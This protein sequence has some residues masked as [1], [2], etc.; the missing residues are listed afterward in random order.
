MKVVADRK[1]LNREIAPTQT[2]S[3]ASISETPP[4]PHRRPEES[5]YFDPQ[6]NPMGTPPPGYPP[7]YRAPSSLQ[8]PNLNSAPPLPPQQP[9]IRPNYGYLNTHFAQVPSQVQYNQYS[10]PRISEP[11]ADKP[12]LPV[13]PLDP[14][15]SGYNHRFGSELQKRKRQA[16]SG[17]FDV[18]NNMNIAAPFEESPLAEG[19]VLIASTTTTPPQE[20]VDPTPQPADLPQVPV[21]TTTAINISELMK[22]RKM[23]LSE[24]SDIVGPTR[25]GIE[26]PVVPSSTSSQS[27]LGICYSSESESE[28]SPTDPIEVPS[29]GPVAEPFQSPL[30]S[31]SFSSP[32]P[33]FV[34]VTTPRDFVAPSAVDNSTHHTASA[35]PPSKPKQIEVDFELVSFVPAALRV[36]RAAP[37]KPKPQS[38]PQPPATHPA[39]IPNPPSHNVD[40]AYEEFM[41][42]ISQLGS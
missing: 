41:A 2:Q 4:F 9:W 3:Q 36:R 25:P 34:D 42:E 6:F 22:R 17:N 29:Q 35:P 21:E 24:S 15:A 16:L 1:Q 39:Q 18:I 12:S 31:S 32:P 38:Q 10:A 28:D 23:V 8:Q 14:S 37:Q 20:I 11:R 13:D 33:S 40:S 5:V 27:V 7:M 26:V 19:P 30:T